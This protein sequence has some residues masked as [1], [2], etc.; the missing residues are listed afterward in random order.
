MADP[1]R[2]VT[3]TRTRVAFAIPSLT[4]GGAGEVQGGPEGVF[5]SLL[6]TIDTSRFDVHLIVDDRDE[7]NLL[8]EVDDRVTVTAIA[9]THR[10][11]RLRA[12]E[13]YP[14]LALARAVRTLQPDVVLATLRMN[15]TCALARPLF[16]KHVSLIC[17]V[18][19]NLT[20][21]LETQR[22]TSTTVKQRAVERLHRVVLDRADLLIAQSTSME[23]DLTARFGPRLGAKIRRI[24]NPVDVEGLLRRA[25][26]APD[27]PPPPGSPQL[28]SVGRLHRQKGYDLLLPA[29]ADIVRRQP[30]A[31]LRILGEGPD[32]A[33]LEAQIDAL[34]LAD[35]VELP[36]FLGDPA[37]HLAAAD[38]YICSS[39]YEGFSNALAEALAV[40]TPA[41][42]PD[43][44]AAGGD[45]VTTANG[46]LVPIATTASLIDG[47][48]RAL[49]TTFDRAAI[50]R[51][52]RER[53][54][55]DAVVLQYQDA[56]LE[57]AEQRSRN[58]PA[59]R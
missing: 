17:R 51:D 2:P 57:A 29:L 5:T 20:G 15:V 49:A 45:L 12:A 56:I 10:R 34:G 47:I 31:R 22:Q 30:D 13:R 24:P 1:G 58:A 41:V 11:V 55:R 27:P 4:R 50:S 53:F 38:L 32:R 35:H 16:P 23:T 19:N 14:V 59:A 18:A 36:G 43:G 8:S 25:A 44:A 46:V 9:P 26:V 42:A 48:D 52:C 37:P 54:S 33:A 3:V 21:A 7:S 28:I 40:G 6:Q 39:R